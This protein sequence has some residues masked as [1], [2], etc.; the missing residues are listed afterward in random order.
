LKRLNW[1][2]N[3]GLIEFKL[4]FVMQREAPV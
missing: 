1:L 4:N 2:F 3:V